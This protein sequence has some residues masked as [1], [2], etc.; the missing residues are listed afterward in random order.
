MNPPALG[1]VGF[2][3]RHF[4]PG[5]LYTFVGAG[6]KSSGMRAV[7]ACLRRV[8]L[9]VRVSTT[10]R[11]GIDEFAAYPAAAVRTAGALAA[12]LAGSEPLLLI[13][14]DID[15]QHGKYGGVVAS[16]LEGAAIPPDTVVL[17][18]G[19]GS[20]GLPLKAPTEWEPVIPSNSRCVFALMGAGA[21]GENIDAACCYNHEGVLS[22]L[23]CA[24]GIFDAPA[25]LTLAAD[26]RGC[27]KGVLPGMD[28]HLVVNQGDLVEKRPIALEL[29]RKLFELHGIRSTL[30]SWQKETVYESTAG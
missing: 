16:L 5:G 25:L 19:D 17:V 28:F 26:S 14:G 15:E 1:L 11:V 13:A 12:C 2:T 18:E 7:A 21:F 9:R 29:V 22:L 20:R 30:L 24:G 4:R 23:G 10:T 6:G 8:G 3:A 27:R